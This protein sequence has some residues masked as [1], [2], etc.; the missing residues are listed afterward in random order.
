[1]PST[2][3]S[4]ST[5]RLPPRLHEIRREIHPPR[6]RPP[7][8]R[9]PPARAARRA[10]IP[11]LHH[12]ARLLHLPPRKAASSRPS[13]AR[14]TRQRP[15]RD[16]RAPAPALAPVR[17][18]STALRKAEAPLRMTGKAGRRAHP[19]GHP[20][21]SA[22]GVEG[23]L[24]F[25]PV[26]R[27][28]CGGG[29]HAARTQNASAGRRRECRRCPSFSVWR[30]KSEAMSAAEA[31]TGTPLRRSFCATQTLHIFGK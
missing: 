14:R 31:V 9:F 7:A 22:S 8:R 23:P 17:G 5:W 21:R 2:P 27:A 18:P 26:A 24:T 29:R 4:R 20:E 12:H 16:H 6:D 28:Y 13:S 10:V 1:M 3:R 15:A 19:S 25:P 30:T 11:R